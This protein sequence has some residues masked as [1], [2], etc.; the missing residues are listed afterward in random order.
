[1]KAAF[2]YMHPF[3]ESM[4]SFVRLREL[5]LGL[6]KLGVE[7]Y[8]FVPYEKSFDLASNIHVISFSNFLNSSG[9][10]KAVYRL[11]KLLYYSKAFP[12]LFSK[13][14]IRSNKI[15]A[16]FIAR[17]A[18]QF[19]TH[20]IDV[21]QVEQDAAIPFGIGL[22]EET[23]IPLIAD[24]HNISSEELVSAGVIDRTGNLFSSLQDMTKKRLAEVDHVLVVSEDMK[25]Y[26]VTNYNCKRTNVSVIPP[27]GRLLF[28]KSV[29][30]TR[31]MPA[32]IV[33]AGLVA[34]R[35]HVDL[36]VNSM[37]FV[38]SQVPHAQFFITNKGEAIRNIK[39]LSTKIGVSP[40]F[41][42][43]N[44]YDRANI[45]FSSCHLG[46]LPSSNDVARK[47]GTPAKL[48]NY[49][50]VG[51]PVV[52]NDIGGWTD[53]IKE[54][55]IGL[56]VSDD[57]EDFGEALVNLLKSPK[58]LQDYAIN[59]M[60]LIAT[61]YNWDNSASTLAKIYPNYTV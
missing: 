43:Y 23:G 36:F 17:L 41:F 3:S 53:I 58:T 18:K 29:L 27:G 44:D 40:E 31:D 42:W 59:A 6:S 30:E 25:D 45:F 19:V 8:I 26:A 39:Q 15:M 56:L 32:K 60:E 33:Y 9:L 55:D 1:M 4:G 38:L 21:I 49:L 34:H 61:K 46:V 28:D 57:P 52:A 13:T 50:S 14:D 47:M 7:C 5:A 51:L 22:K 37:P 11:S 12:N 20:D 2:V 54:H 24:L 35:E 16:Q 10:A 48:F